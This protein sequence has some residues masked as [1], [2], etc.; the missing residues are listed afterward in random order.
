MA[1]VIFL[2]RTVE[3]TTKLVTIVLSNYE[4]RFSSG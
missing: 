3:H 1:L 4:G 2:L